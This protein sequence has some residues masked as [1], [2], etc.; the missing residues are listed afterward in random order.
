MKR[1]VVVD[2]RKYNIEIHRQV[3]EPIDAPRLIIVSYMPTQ[4]AREILRIALRA[5]R[6]FTPEPHEVWVVDNNSPQINSGWLRDY[7]DVNVVFNRTEPIP[8][9]ERGWWRNGK[10]Q[11]KW[12][13]YANAIALELA[14]RLIDQQALYLMTLHMDTMPCKN[15]WLSFIKSKLNNKVAAAGV[16]LDRARTKEGILHVLGYMV[17]YQL[18]KKLQLSF[19]PQLPQYD[20][21]DLVSIRLRNAGYDIFACSNSLWDDKLVATLPLDSPFRSLHVDRS[22]DDA[23][24]VIF[25]HLGRGIQKSSG[26]LMKGTT[27][28][29]WIEFA[30]DQLF[31]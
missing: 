18:F 4:Q 11:T 29:A 23:G 2:G 14:I 15:G 7:P 21:G 27:S 19:L 12:G 6:H 26:K 31:S 24:N 13:S 3:Q 17:N 30:N 25:L 20:V 9:P 16:R 22:F 28:E 1:K 10:N 5:I 8:A